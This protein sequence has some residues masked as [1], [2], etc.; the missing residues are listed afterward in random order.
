MQKLLNKAVIQGDPRQFRH[1]CF[2]LYEMRFKR[3]SL[4]MAGHLTLSALFC[5]FN[6]P[7]QLD[8]IDAYRKAPLSIKAEE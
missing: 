1:C 4:T 5:A 7:S 8:L 3:E 6:S 2:M